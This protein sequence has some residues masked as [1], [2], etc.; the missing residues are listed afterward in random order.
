MSENT[1]NVIHVNIGSS[2]FFTETDLRKIYKAR[3][4]TVLKLSGKRLG[5]WVLTTDD[6][7]G[8]EG[9]AFGIDAYNHNTLCGEIH[10]CRCDLKKAWFKIITGG[11]K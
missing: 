3:P 5:K 9:C 1:T 7:A 6:D 8:C 11:P 10:F 4:G 2:L